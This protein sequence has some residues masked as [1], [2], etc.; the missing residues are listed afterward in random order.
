MCVYYFT[1]TGNVALSSHLK[2]HYIVTRFSTGRDTWPPDQPKHFTPLVLIHRQGRRTKK[3]TEAVMKATMKGHINAFLSAANNRTTKDLQEL[4]S[5]L[6]PPPNTMQ[7]RTILV[8]GSPGVGKSVLLKQISYLW[9][10]GS[11]LT[12]HEFLF[13]LH[14][15]D[16]V[17]QQITSLHDLVHFFYHYDK[18]TTKIAKFCTAY[19]EKCKGKSLIILFDGYDELPEELRDN[20]FIAKILRRDILPMCAVVVSSRPHASIRLNDDVTSRVEILGFSE[21]DQQSFIQQSLEKTPQKIPELEKYLKEH[22][23]ITSLCFIPFNMTVL[24]FLFKQELALPSNSTDLYSLFI[25]LTICRHLTKSGISLQEEITTLDSLPPPYSSTISQFSKLAFDA[26]GRNQLVF[27][28]SDIK[29]ECPE[30][31]KDVNAFG[32]LQA[33]EHIGITC[34]SLSFNFIHLSVQEFL[35][36]YYVACLSEDKELS[37]LEE[38]FWNKTF[39]NTF[40]FYVAMTKGQRPAFKRFFAGSKSSASGSTLSID[41]NILD[42]R[43]KCINLFRCFSEVKDKH[44]TGIIE[45]LF[46]GKII[47]FCYCTLSPSDVESIALLLSCSSI[48]QWLM[49]NLY[50]CC[51]QQYGLSLLSR[52]LI[53]NSVTIEKFWLA[54]NLLSSNSDHNISDIVIHCAVKELEIGLNHLGE[55]EEFFST[56]LSHPSSVLE[57]LYMESNKLSSGT[58]KRLFTSLQQKNK[59]K[60]LQLAYNPVTDS[61][62]N[63]IAE[64]LKSNTTLEYLNLY[65][66]KITVS[67]AL[68]I[69]ASLQYNNTL[70]MLRLPKYYSDYVTSEIATSL[71]TINKKRSQENEVELEIKFSLS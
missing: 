65:G 71:D 22:S 24:L 40:A 51:M 15:R 32:L 20:S 29:E 27:T 56:I 16:P 68:E 48:K 6:E 45:Q 7:A 30:I 52:P 57:E 60:K 14:L 46:S 5:Y 66:T 12:N 59:L 43:F 25:C 1:I 21:Q 63:I 42:D 33:V 61:D 19:L 54:N 3:E 64:M 38:N 28:L 35:A 55:T 69:I 31:G 8:E 67:G 23:V 70:F 44:L 11:V 34:K 17:V 9:A 41:R 49:L 10:D 53:T 58:I 47:N 39:S 4:L 2:T 62:C 36:A 37:I 18:E 50:S 26:L 13:L